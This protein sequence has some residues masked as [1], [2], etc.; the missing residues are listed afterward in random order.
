MR[1]AESDKKEQSRIDG[2]VWPYLYP[3]FSWYKASVLTGRGARMDSSPDP[4]A[5]HNCNVYTRDWVYFSCVF[6]LRL[7]TDVFS[8]NDEGN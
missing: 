2:G 3:G 8:K 6:V 1:L 7:F 5:L 4:T